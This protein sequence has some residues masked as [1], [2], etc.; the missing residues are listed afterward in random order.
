MNLKLMVAFLVIT[1]VPVYAQIQQPGVDKLKA[2]AKQ[3]VKIISADK[4][5]A[6]TYCEMAKLS[7]QGVQERDVKKTRELS[8]RINELEDKLGP[9]YVALKSGLM[10]IDPESQDGQEISSILDALDTLCED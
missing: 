6:Q 4:V 10:D 8:A 9:E 5:K 1:A 2:D 3:V 7:D